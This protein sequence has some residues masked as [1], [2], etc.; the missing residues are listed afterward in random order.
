M[1]NFAFPF[2]P[3]LKFPQ[4]PVNVEQR[5]FIK[6]KGF[7]MW[8]D[9]ILPIITK[10]FSKYR[11]SQYVPILLWSIIYRIHPVYITNG[12]II[13]SLLNHFISNY[14][15]QTKFAKV[16]FSQVSVHRG[17]P[18]APAMHAPPTTHAPLR[19]RGVRILLECMLVSVLQL[20]L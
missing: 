13:L 9:N 7:R 19:E 12:Y 3:L 8:M 10:T 4:W 17:T 1:N 6:I 5:M 11:L 18:P 20:S 16:M 2:S 15:P 14:R